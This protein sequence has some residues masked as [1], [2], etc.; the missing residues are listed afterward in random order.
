M[1]SNIKIILFGKCILMERVLEKVLELGLS[2]FPLPKGYSYV[3]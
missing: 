3:I 1:L 2:S